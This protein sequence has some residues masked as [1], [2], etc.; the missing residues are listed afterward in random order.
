MKEQEKLGL[1]MQR[2][3][4]TGTF[5]DQKMA[6]LLFQAGPYTLALDAEQVME[7]AFLPKTLDVAQTN[8]KQLLTIESM[9][10]FSLSQF[11]NEQIHSVNKPRIIKY[12]YQ[13]KVY[14]LIIEEPH[15]FLRINLNEI[16]AMP[17]LITF[18]RGNGC[19]W[20]FFI[21]DRGISFIIDLHQLN[22]EKAGLED[23]RS[24][25]LP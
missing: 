2:E 21:R 24:G 7:M 4:Q 13:D 5:E 19:L 16:F 17:R 23:I 20:G 11:L 3:E 1:S 25:R 6:L 10:V 9:P 8:S 18:F 22:I 15:S 12:R 14:G